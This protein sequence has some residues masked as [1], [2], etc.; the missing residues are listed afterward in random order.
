MCTHVLVKRARIVLLL[1]KGAPVFAARGSE[2]PNPGAV[3][4]LL[5]IPD[6]VVPLLTMQVCSNLGVFD[7][8]DPA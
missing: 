7:L 8:C 6:E 5:T 4:P 3:V 2:I 1:L